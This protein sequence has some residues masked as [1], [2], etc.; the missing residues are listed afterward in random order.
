MVIRAKGVNVGAISQWNTSQTRG[1][2]A[3][4]AFGGTPPTGAGISY[5]ASGP[6][7]AYEKVPGNVSGTTISVNRYDLYVARM[8]E[9]F[10]AESDLNMLSEQHSPF[11]IV[12]F[13]NTPT[14]TG[15]NL[16]QLKYQYTGC[17]FSNLGR[18]QSTTGDRIVNVNATIEYVRR[19]KM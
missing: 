8:E 19:K 17:W 11:D 5:P 12:E 3:V 18:T 14:A 4:Y 16:S 15:A 2:T 7:E 9:V 10:G 6:G 13:W 1:H